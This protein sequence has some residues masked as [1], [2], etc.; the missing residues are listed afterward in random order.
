MKTYV[1]T[2][3]F[4]RS[5]QLA[6]CLLEYQKYASLPIDRHIV[7]QGH[8]PID[9]ERNNE[10]IKLIVESYGNA[11]LWDP[12]K[13]IGSA[14]TQSWALERLQLEDEAYWINL[15]PDS[16]CRIKGWD[17][18]M[19]DVLDN[20]PQCVTISCQSPMVQGFV[21]QRGQEFVEKSVAFR[22][23]GIL[24]QPTPFNLS[25]FRYS[26][27]KEIGGVPQGFPCWGELEGPLHYQA[28]IRG[29]YHSYLL[30]FV[31]D[32][33]GKFFHPHTNAE[34]KDLHARTV[35]PEQFLGSYGEFL[36]YRYPEIAG[37]R[38]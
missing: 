9:T 2:V 35:G 6:R 33:K 38:I 4:C 20:D 10:E 36:N 13:D 24:A 26:F 7:I 21:Q 30:D 19:K 32:E 34:W 28:T 8:Y 31:E 18:A 16:A 11:E 3:A 14:Q 27:I 23:T 25:M 22:R 1:L 5:A 17:I 12:G 15:D 37:L 29:R